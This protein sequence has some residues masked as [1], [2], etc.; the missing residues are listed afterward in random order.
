MTPL[1]QM[2]SNPIGGF[3]VIG[4]SVGAEAVT[5]EPRPKR[6]AFPAAP[7]D[8]PM[9]PM[10]HD[11]LDGQVALVTG[12]TRGIG[13]QVAADLYDLGA[14]VYAGARNPRDLAGA[15]TDSDD[16]VRPIKIDVTDED[17]LQAAVRTAI[18]ETGRLDV[19]V[20]NAAIGDFRGSDLMHLD[21]ARFDLV[22]AT[23]LRG[24]ALLTKHAL[25]H[26][27][28]Q[29]GGRVVNVSSG[30]GAL[31]GGMGGNAPAYRIS[32]TA[33]NGLTAALHGAY[34]GRGLLTNAVCPGWVRTEM[35]GPE[36]PRTVEQ[37]ADTI[38]WLCRF[39]S[40]S[41][42]GRFWRDRQVI[43]W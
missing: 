31:D 26:L 40:G 10:L 7:M 28:T 3:G 29:P 11:R 18:Q 2:R 14:I 15:R 32:K 20:N 9:K 24:P 38:V 16:R 30:M 13:A 23:N 39:K 41:P 43:P 34:A 1:S 36:A 22:L 37:G 4:A 8:A 6:Q 42:A 21:T 35:G 17:T 5:R 25:P 27:L 12:A 33:L 19:V